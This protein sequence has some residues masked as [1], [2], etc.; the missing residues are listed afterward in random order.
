MNPCEEILGF[1]DTKYWLIGIPLISIIIPLTFYGDY[2]IEGDEP[3]W[4]GFLAT[5]AYSSIIWFGGRKIII[6]VLK[7]FP[8]PGETTKSIFYLLLFLISYVLL[9]STLGNLGE[10]YFRIGHCSFMDWQRGFGVSLIISVAVVAIYEG[11]YLYHQLRRSLTE[12]ERLKR[13]ESESQLA[14]LKNQINPHFLFNSLNTLA[15]IIPEDQGRAVGYVENLS[16]AYR[17]ILAVQNKHLITLEEELNFTNHY[18]QVLKYRFEEA[19][20]MKIDVSESDKNRFMVPLGLQMLIENA[21]KHNVV[22]R[23]RPLEIR[24]ESQGDYV[25]VSNN[26]QVREDSVDST[27]L[28]LKNLRDRYRIVCKAEMIIN[29]SETEF[30]VMLPLVEIK[31]YNS[32][33]S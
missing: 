16:S 18:V 7:R 1:N 9:V 15:S 19:L 24:I 23:N 17:H 12:Q 21:I 25:T 3:L 10:A 28:G 33:V 13:K 4:T 20:V 5:L 30:I 2:Y 32:E 27:G 6:E 14:A 8:I 26:L 31:S 11:T 29:R 22:T